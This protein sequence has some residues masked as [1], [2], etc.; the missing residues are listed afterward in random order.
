LASRVH[1]K[2]LN[3]DL[4]PAI[5]KLDV[6]VKGL[7][8]T[9]MLGGYKSAFRGRGLEFADYREYSPSEDDASL[10]DWKASLRTNT[11]VV[12]EFVEER[13]LDVFFLIDCGSGMVFGSTEKLKNEYSAEFA[14]SLAYVILESGDN[15]GYCL[16]NNEIRAQSQPLRGKDQ[17]YKFTRDLIN[18][19]NY[20]GRFHIDAALKFIIGTQSIRNSSLV[21]L[22]SDFIGLKGDW[23]RYIKSAGKKFDFVGV[24]VRDPRDQT[25]PADSYKVSLENPHTGSQMVVDP[26]LIKEQYEKLVREE[27]K[28]IREEFLRS[29]ADFLELNTAKSFVE[30]LVAFFIR[31]SKRWK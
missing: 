19:N 3:V 17:F 30:P 14:A 21:I 5:K 8:N 28:K 13:N 24:M 23:K 31:R 1:R 4:T 11:L 25:L 20:G 16:F 7:L 6:T 15:V 9:K 26:I 22:V 12:K 2:K 18:P 10:I 29:G 27:E